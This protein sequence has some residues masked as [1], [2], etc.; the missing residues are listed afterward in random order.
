MA[1][2]YLLGTGPWTIVMIDGLVCST[3][4]LMYCTT[5]SLCSTRN[6]TEDMYVYLYVSLCAQ[7]TGGSAACCGVGSHTGALLMTSYASQHALVGEYWS[8]SRVAYACNSTCCG[9]SGAFGMTRLKGYD[10]LRVL[11]DGNLHIDPAEVGTCLGVHVACTSRKGRRGA[12][13]V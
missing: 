10:H 7:K 4:E 3:L 12:E 8:E 6:R 9:E 13:G 1:E 11:V 2:Y 5:I